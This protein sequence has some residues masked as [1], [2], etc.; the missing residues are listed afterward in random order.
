STI[1]SQSSSS[2]LHTSATGT[3]TGPVVPVVS[4]TGSVVPLVSLVSLVP[5]VVSGGAV[6]LVV[7][8][9]AVVP[10][11]LVVPVEPV[12]PVVPGIGAVV[13][14]VDVMPALAEPSV[15]V[16]VV[17]VPSL[18]LSEVDVVEP[19]GCAAEPELLSLVLQ[20]GAA[21]SVAAATSVNNECGAGLIRRW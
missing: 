14:G 12:V 9:T 10:V 21:T 5:V 8:S 16:P 13:V 2:L 7:S 11:L 3:H 17:A 20:A 6:V 19:S 18:V 4:S 15:G 1:P